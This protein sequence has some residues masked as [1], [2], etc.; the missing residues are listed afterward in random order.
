MMT[1]LEI[2]I[3]TLQFQCNIT[4]ETEGTGMMCAKLPTKQN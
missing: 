4:Q 3:L 1:P 2:T